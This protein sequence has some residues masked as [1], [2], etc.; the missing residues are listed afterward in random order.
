[1][2]VGSIWP[3]GAWVGRSTVRWRALAAVWSLGVPRKVKVV[4]CARGEAVK[5]VNYINLTLGHQRGE[6]EAHQSDRRQQR[7][8]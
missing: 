4:P 8:A 7:R 1:M 3:V 6:G 2:V 5:L